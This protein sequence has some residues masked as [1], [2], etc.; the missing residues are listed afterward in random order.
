[1]AVDKAALTEQ[2]EGVA[3]AIAA[4]PRHPRGYQGLVTVEDVVVVVCYRGEDGALYYADPSEISDGKPDLFLREFVMLGRRRCVSVVEL[5]ER[6]MPYVSPQTASMWRG[7]K[8]L[9]K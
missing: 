7:L 9:F 4:F 1:M 2:L 6:F 5:L 3:E 8:G